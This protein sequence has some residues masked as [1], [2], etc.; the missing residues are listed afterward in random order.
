[1]IYEYIYYDGFLDKTKPVRLTCFKTIG[2]TDEYYLIVDNAEYPKYDLT[3]DMLGTF[4]EIQ[5][6]VKTLN[7]S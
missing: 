7:I 5:D 3:W 6:C 4:K 2:T 1:M